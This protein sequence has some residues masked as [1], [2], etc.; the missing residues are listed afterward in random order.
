MCQFVDVG[1]LPAFE[2][3]LEQLGLPPPLDR[4]D[5]P[6]FDRQLDRRADQAN[7]LRRPH[8]SVEHQGPVDRLR[9]RIPGHLAA[10]VGLLPRPE[11]PLRCVIDQPV[12]DVACQLGASQSGHLH[13][14]GRFQH[15]GHRVAQLQHF[16]IAIDR[17]YAPL[18]DRRCDHGEASE[19][20]AGIE[21][22]LEC[23]GMD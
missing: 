11:D 20:S 17:P 6:L 18:H 9:S 23:A 12:L 3:P 4:G 22:R 7:F 2:P 21:S 8:R 1:V 5:L 19:P 15:L 16:R 13:L 10:R 14:A